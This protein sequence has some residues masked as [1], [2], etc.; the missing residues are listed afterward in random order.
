RRGSL[1]RGVAQG[2]RDEQDGQPTGALLLAHG[3]PW[4]EGSLQ[5]LL[6]PPLQHRVG[7]VGGVAL[8][9]R[10]VATPRVVPPLPPSSSHGVVEVAA[11]TLILSP[12]NFLS[13]LLK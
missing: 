10:G 13:A 9:S 6:S 3:G 5:A 1:Q 2:T 4:P 8:L 11:L 7:G 12:L